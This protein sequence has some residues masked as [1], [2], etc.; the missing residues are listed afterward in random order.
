MPNNTGFDR[1]SDNALASVSDGEATKTSA[2]EH[3]VIVK[4][5]DSSREASKEW[6]LMFSAFSVVYVST[7]QFVRVAVL[8]LTVPTCSSTRQQVWT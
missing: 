5:S 4:P 1:A 7:H 6:H 3:V 2:E 8:F